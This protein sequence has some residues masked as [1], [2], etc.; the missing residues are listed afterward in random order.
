MKTLI[1]VGM[2]IGSLIGGYLPTLFG[3]SWLS[4]ATVLGNGLGGMLGVYIGY[5]LSNIW[6]I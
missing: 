6:G 5:Q 1:W 2:I 3:A 4:F